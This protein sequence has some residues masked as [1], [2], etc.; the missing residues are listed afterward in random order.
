LRTAALESRYQRFGLIVRSFRMAL[1]KGKCESFVSTV[2]FRASHSLTSG[3]AFEFPRGLSAI[4]MSLDTLKMDRDKPYRE[5][6][7]LLNA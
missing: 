5:R 3:D 4:R 6:C 1:A 7:L 2:D